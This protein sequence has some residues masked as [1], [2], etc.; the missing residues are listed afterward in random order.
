M[1]KFVSL[2]IVLIMILPVLSSIAENTKTSQEIENIH[3]GVRYYNELCSV[4]DI[5]VK[6]YY[7]SDFPEEFIIVCKDLIDENLYRELSYYLVYELYDIL[8][9]YIG[10]ETELPYTRV[11]IF[12]DGKI[13]YSMSEEEFITYEEFINYK[14]A[15]MVE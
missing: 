8:E 5:P 11:N 15:G 4:N 9:G 12:Y 7:Y 1:R 3:E 6:A 13:L 2:V 14:Y 10:P